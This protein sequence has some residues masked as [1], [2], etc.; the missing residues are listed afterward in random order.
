ME[1]KGRAVVATQTR[2]GH[3]GCGA[4]GRASTFGEDTKLALVRTQGLPRLPHHQ[5]NRTRRACRNTNS[6]TSPLT[7]PFRL[8]N[9]TRQTH[10]LSTNLGPFTSKNLHTPQLRA[11][12]KGSY[13]GSSSPF[14]FY[15]K[16]ITDFPHR[17]SIPHSPFLRRSPIRRHR[18]LR[19]GLS[20]CDP[21]PLSVTKVESDASIFS[22]SAFL[23]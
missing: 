17:T 14:L 4:G 9:R 19:R 2:E 8:H 10:R 18:W 12:V 22:I 11:F 6:A 7:Y 16:P 23:R 15:C 3:G 13:Y 1:A 20:S 5:G 21:L